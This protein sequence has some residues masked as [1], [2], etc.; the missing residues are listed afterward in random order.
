[1]PDPIHDYIAYL[2]EAFPRSLCVYE[3]R[4]RAERRHLSR[5]ARV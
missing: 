5:L 2:A 4:R 3:R 1:M